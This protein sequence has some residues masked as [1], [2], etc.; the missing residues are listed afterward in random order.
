M[1]DLIRILMLLFALY[2]AANAKDILSKVT[3]P[4]YYTFVKY[5]TDR[6]YIM[7]GCSDSKV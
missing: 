1:S 3:N 6:K 4:I 2:A 5:S 7:A